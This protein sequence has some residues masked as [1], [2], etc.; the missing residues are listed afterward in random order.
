M[1]STVL[2]TLATYAWTPE[3]LVKRFI[4][5][6]GPGEVDGTKIRWVLGDYEYAMIIWDVSVYC[7]IG[8]ADWAHDIFN[9]RYM[10]EI[11]CPNEV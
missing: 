11:V 1:T 10:V 9:P 6:L 4:Q 5:L 7:S 3:F 2:E 8:Q